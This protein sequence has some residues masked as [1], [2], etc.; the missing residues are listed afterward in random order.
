[1][2][3]SKQRARVFLDLAPLVA[4]DA[5]LTQ[6]ISLIRSGNLSMGRRY[7]LGFA[8]FLPNRAVT[9][10]AMLLSAGLMHLMNSGR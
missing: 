9:Y 4:S 3:L 8:K 5:T 10:D 1:M 2:S 7:L 6:T